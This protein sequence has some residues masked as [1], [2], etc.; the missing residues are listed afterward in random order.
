MVITIY[1]PHA[2]VKAT[3]ASDGEIVLTVEPP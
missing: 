1:H 2:T 3:I